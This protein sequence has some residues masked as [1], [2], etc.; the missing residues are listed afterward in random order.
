MSDTMD[1][2]EMA[3]ETGDPSKCENV[4]E[5]FQFLCYMA[6]AVESENVS[7]CEKIQGNASL[8]GCY[9]A[10]AVNTD[11]VSI[12][13]MIEHEEFEYACYTGVASETQNI[14]VCDKIRNE[15]IRHEC[16][17]KVEKDKGQQ[18]A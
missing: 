13:E 12:C 14:T 17:E 3:S 6:A 10:V 16:I 2:I 5:S 15:Q 4:S 7:V 1:S 11:N 9:M 18:L 8:M